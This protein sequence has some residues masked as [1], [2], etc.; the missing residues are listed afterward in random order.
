MVSGSIP[1]PAPGERQLSGS[2]DI[3]SDVRSGSAVDIAGTARSVCYPCYPPGGCRSATG[4]I[5]PLALAWD[6]AAKAGT[7]WNR[8]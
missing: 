5:R 3:G 1:R 6:G 2:L 7:A 4:Q 8:C